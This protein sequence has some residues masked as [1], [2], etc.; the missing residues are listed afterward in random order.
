MG[1]S[2]ALEQRIELLD[3]VELLHD[4]LTKSLCQTVFQQTRTTERERQWSLHTL[5]SFWTKVI[6]RAP[7]SLTQAL[8]EAALGNGS[9]W[10]PV[11]A[12][13]E[14]FC[15]RCQNLDWRFFANL[16]AAFVTQVL[17]Q[18]QSASTTLQTSSNGSSATC[19]SGS[20][21][22]RRIAHGC[23]R[24]NISILPR[25]R[26]RVVDVASTDNTF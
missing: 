1:T 17:P 5:A 24:S 25:T 8:Q 14:A 22:R 10:P 16:H 7:Q 9:G 4:Y 2:A 18:A 23:I 15:Q 12:S 20:T 26:F 21:I 19:A 3:T 11:G 13:P 6:L